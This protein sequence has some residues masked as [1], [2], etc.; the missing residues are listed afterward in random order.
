MWMW[1][2][3]RP[4]L[5]A[6]MCDTWSQGCS[7]RLKLPSFCIST[8]HLEMGLSRSLPSV[9]DSPLYKWNVKIRGCVPE[10]APNNEWN[11]ML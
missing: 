5:K 4:R 11:V 9:A 2:T 8:W 7:V 3:S 1:S 6:C 10:T